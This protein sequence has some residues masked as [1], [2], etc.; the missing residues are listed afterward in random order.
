MSRYIRFEQDVV[1]SIE[2]FTGSE[3]VLTPSFV[4]FWK[5]PAVFGQWTTS[6]FVID[7]VTYSCA[8][9]YMMAEK[10]RL[11]GDADVEQQILRSTNPKQQKSLGRKVRGFDNDLWNEKRLDIVIQG[12]IAKFSQNSHMAEELLATGTRELVEASPRD[13]IWGIGLRA[14]NPIIVDKAQWRGLNLLGIALMET[15]QFLLD[16]I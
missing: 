14:D 3:V 2:N 6:P 11:F 10:A 15:R 13:T 4:F 12:N 5:P 16:N 7:G 1:E 8:E 9:Q